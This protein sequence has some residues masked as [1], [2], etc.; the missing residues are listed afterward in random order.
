MVDILRGIRRLGHPGVLLWGFVTVGLATSC[1]ILV[2]IA[3]FHLEPEGSNYKIVPANWAL[4][5]LYIANKE[6]NSLVAGILGFSGLA[7]SHF[8]TQSGR[9]H[10]STANGGRSAATPEDTTSS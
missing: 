10:G 9:L 8:F 2:V 3:G 1:L 5:G 6:N 7:W 4:A